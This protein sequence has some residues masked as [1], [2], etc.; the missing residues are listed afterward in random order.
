MSSSPYVSRG[1]LKLAHALATF[2]FNPTG[3][4]CADLGASTG[5]FTDCLLQHGASKVYANDTAYGEIAWKLPQGPPRRG[6]GTDQ[7]PPRQTAAARRTSSSPT[8]AGPNKP[9]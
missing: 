7:R 5:G 8:S 1:G 6:H 9:C 4:T 2:S 3:L